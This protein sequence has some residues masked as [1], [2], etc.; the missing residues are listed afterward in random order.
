MI[1][2][3]ASA[4]KL[5]QFEP[6]GSLGPDRPG[7]DRAALDLDRLSAG[8]LAELRP[9]RHARLEGERGVERPFLRDDRA[10]LPPDRLVLLGQQLTEV[11]DEGVELTRRERA[12][13]GE[14]HVLTVTESDTEAAVADVLADTEGLRSRAA[15]LGVERVVVRSAPGVVCVRYLP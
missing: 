14:I 11:V 6:V 10:I 1:T 15:R 8:E 4:V 7:L 9:L 2:R 13:T 5:S 3:S 12:G